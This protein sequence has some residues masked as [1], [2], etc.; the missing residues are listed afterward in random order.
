MHREYFNLKFTMLKT[1]ISTFRIGYSQKGWTDGKIGAEWIKIFDKQTKHKVKKGEYQLLIVDG[2]NSHYTIAF[3]MYAREN[4]ILVLCYPAHTTHIYQGLDVVIFAVLKHFLMEERDKWFHT[5]AQAMDKNNFLAIY[6][7]AH[8]C[9][10]TPEN[11]KSAFKKTGVWP[12]NPSVITEE[13]LAPSKATSVQAHLPVPMSDPA[14]DALA[15]MFRGLASINNAGHD[16]EDAHNDQASGP[17]DVNKQCHAVINTAVEVLAQT[18]L[19]HLL[20]TTLTT[21]R[22]HAHHFA[23]NH[24]SYHSKSTSH[25]PTTNGR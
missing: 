2:H 12:Y 24:P 4:L 19:S 9:A 10:L 14:T 17:S 3:L 16:T 7:A 5:W 13:M 11:V 6:S 21:S 18:N 25:N 8:V 23:H 22:R 15:I 20:A 1:L